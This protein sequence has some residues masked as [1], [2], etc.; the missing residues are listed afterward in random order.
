[1]SRKTFEQW[2][3][4]AACGTGWV[5]DPW[6]LNIS[7]LDQILHPEHGAKGL[8]WTVSGFKLVLRILGAPRRTDM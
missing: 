5:S 3:R 4:G 7:I 8:G 1:M 2:L 6:Q